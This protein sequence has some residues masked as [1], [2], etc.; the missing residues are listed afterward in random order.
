MNFVRSPIPPEIS[1]FRP[2]H[3]LQTINNM[4]LPSPMLLYLKCNAYLFL[5]LLPDVLNFISNDVEWKIFHSIPLQWHY[6]TIFSWV[7]LITEDKIL[8]YGWITPGTRFWALFSGVLGTQFL[9]FWYF[10]GLDLETKLLARHSISS[11]NNVCW[12]LWAT[13]TCI[14]KYWFAKVQS[15]CNRE[16]RGDHSLHNAR[17]ER[18]LLTHNKHIEIDDS[19][20]RSKSRCRGRGFFGGML[21]IFTVHICQFLQI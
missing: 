5:F 20:K 8:I 3:L 9:S 18:K 2:L 21:K 12:K 19:C 7:S 10:C 13:I 15:E 4:V 11:V 16:Y 1:H 17:N 14:S 6:L